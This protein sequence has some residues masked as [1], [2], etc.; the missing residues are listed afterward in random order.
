MCY[1]VLFILTQ[2]E[3]R[4]GKDLDYNKRRN[5]LSKKS[6]TWLVYDSMCMIKLGKEEKKGEKLQKQSF[7]LLCHPQVR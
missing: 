3:K 6:T 4:R 2:M 7:S 5:A 1:L